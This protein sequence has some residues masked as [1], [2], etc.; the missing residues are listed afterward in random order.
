MKSAVSPKNSPLPVVLA[1]FTA[2][3]ANN[4]VMIIPTAPPTPWQGNT[5][6]VSS[7][8]VL[9]FQCTTTLLMIEANVPMNKLEGMVTKPAAGVIAT[10]PTT[11]PIQNPTAEGFLP[12]A[13][14]KRIH[15]NP[16]AAAAVLVVA[17]AEAANAPAPTALPA[18][19]PNH[20]NHSKPVPR[21]TKGMF[22]GAI[23]AFFSVLFLK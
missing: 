1:E 12:R 23:A 20:P 8:D 11:D 15:A 4:A 21:R 10:R 7:K 3:L 18:L 14:S 22:A 2:T 13:T 17:N 16:A 19:N 5:S 6:S 9:D